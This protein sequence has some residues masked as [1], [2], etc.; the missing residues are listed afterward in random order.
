LAA[1]PISSCSWL[2]STL[3]RALTC[4]GGSAPPPPLLS[5]VCEERPAANGERRHVAIAAAGG[6][7]VPPG[8]PWLCKRP[9][10]GAP[11]GL[12]VQGV[13]VRLDHLPRHL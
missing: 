5:S 12:A 2:A 8:L 11:G 6:E 3:L 10:E 4:I 7:G 9:E 13:L 1:Q